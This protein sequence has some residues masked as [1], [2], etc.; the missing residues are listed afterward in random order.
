MATMLEKWQAMPMKTWNVRDAK[1]GTSFTVQAKNRAGV[2]GQLRDRWML[3][4]SETELRATV[5]VAR[6][7]K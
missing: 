5:S 6:A 7:K 1:T 3:S 2:I 4:E